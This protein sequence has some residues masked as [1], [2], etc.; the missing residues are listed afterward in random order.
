MSATNTAT[1]LGD[2][3]APLHDWLQS[4]GPVGAVAWIVLLS[5][6]IAVPV[7]L[8]SRSMWSGSAS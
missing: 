5:L 4:L 3:T 6:L 8:L 2:V 1:L 7:I